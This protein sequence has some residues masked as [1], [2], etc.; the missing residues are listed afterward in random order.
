MAINTLE[1]DG[2]VSFQI[3]CHLGDQFVA[4]L[5]CNKVF[6]FLG[7][8]PVQTNSIRRSVLQLNHLHF[9]VSG[10]PEIDKVAS[11]DD[12]MVRPVV[13]HHLKPGNFGVR[14]R[15]CNPQALVGIDAV[16]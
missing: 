16:V 2:H 14:Q 13:S 8:I 6:Y 3:Q 15:T 12:L 11:R 4:G 10:V 7:I 5:V 9:D 1:H